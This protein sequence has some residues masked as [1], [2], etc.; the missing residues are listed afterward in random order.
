[1]K[2]IQ[3]FPGHMAKA[4]RLV[5][6]K[7]GLVDIVFELLDA[8]IPVSSAN[9]MLAEIIKNKPRLIIL[10][11]ADLADPKDVADWIG[12]FHRNGKAAVA[13]NSLTGDPKPEIIKAARV[14]LREQLA[15]D[16]ERGMQERSIRALVVGIPNVGKSQFINRLAGRPATQTG[17]KPGITKKQQYVRVADELELLDNP[18]I[19]W[20]KFDDP[21]VG[22]NLALLGSIKD[23]IL[24]LEDVVQGGIRFLAREYPGAL[25]ARYQL[26]HVDWNDFAATLDAIGRRRGCLIAGH[27]VDYERV[28]RLFLYDLVESA[29]SAHHLRKCAY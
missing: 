15:K 7:L 5:E 25:E 10:N 16:I 13:T 20:P 23:E 17:D 1:M 21:N 2:Q 24:P 11:K 28:I 8:R 22:M 29:S 4:R 27:G 9:P 3:W 12:Y 19:L 14:A 6:E 26:E 18:G